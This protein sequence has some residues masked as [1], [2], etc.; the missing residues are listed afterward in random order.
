VVAERV[1]DRAERDD[2]VEVLATARHEEREQLE[3]RQLR[4]VG[5]VLV[6]RRPD[7]LNHHARRSPINAPAYRHAIG[8]TDV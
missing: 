7:S 6:S 1:A 8:P 5:R 2:D 3:R 4:A